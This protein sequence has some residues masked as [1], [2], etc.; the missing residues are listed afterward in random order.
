MLL[1]LYANS[2]EFNR[3]L[4]DLQ[5]VLAGDFAHV[6]ALFGLLEAY[7]PAQ[8]QAF[9]DSR[10]YGLLF[11]YLFDQLAKMQFAG[12]R[13]LQITA[14]LVCWLLVGDSASATFQTEEKRLVQI[15]QVCTTRDAIRFRNEEVKAL[16]L[17]LC[18]PDTRETP[19]GWFYCEYCIAWIE[20]VSEESESEE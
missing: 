1:S 6:N 9:F 18:A 20:D 15:L 7:T 16:I 13:F 2:S 10:L 3:L 14:R 11:A 4:P 12:G 5:S 17:R 8:Q 19:F